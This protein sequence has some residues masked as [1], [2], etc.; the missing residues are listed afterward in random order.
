M[1]FVLV[2]GGGGGESSVAAPPQAKL[3][4][5]LLRVLLGSI[6]GKDASIDALLVEELI[7]KAYG[8]AGVF[9]VTREAERKHIYGMTEYDVN[10]APALKKVDNGIAV[11]NVARSASDIVSTET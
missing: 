7:E 1:G 5:K 6:Q 9:S 11:A 10:D 2:R 3:Q 4:E 8:F